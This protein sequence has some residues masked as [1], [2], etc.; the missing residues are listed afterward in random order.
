MKAIKLFNLIGNMM[1]SDSRSFDIKIE[2]E[3]GELV[4]AEAIIDRKEKM[5]IIKPYCKNN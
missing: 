5:I 1:L 4:D 3:N 2:Q